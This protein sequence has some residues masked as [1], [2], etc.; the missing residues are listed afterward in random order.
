M[1]NFSGASRAFIIGINN[2]GETVCAASARISTQQGSAEEILQKSTANT[3]NASLIAKVLRSGHSSVIEHTFFNLAF[4]DVSVA[5]EQFMIEFRLASFT[6]KSRRYVDFS[7]VGYYT[8][9]FPTDEPWSAALKESYS[10]HMDYLFSEY[11]FLLS[12][13]IPKEDARFVLPYCYRSNFY[14]S[15]NARELTHVLY[16]MLY[17]RGKAFGEIRTIG[18]DLLKQARELC[19]G[20]FED[21]PKIQNKE[22]VLDLSD[23]IPENS[24]GQSAREKVEL[25]AAP[26]NAATVAAKAALISS[27]Q[28]P[29]ADADKILNNS[30]VKGEIIKRLTR[31]S[32]PRELEALN[33]TFRLNGI[34]LAGVTHVVRHRMQNICVPS[35]KNA[36]RDNYVLPETVAENNELLRRYEEIF[37]RN[38]ELC[39]NLAAQGV[40]EEMLVYYTLS[41]NTLDLLTTMNAREL[42]LFLRL[43]TCMRAQWE[44]RGY[45]MDMLKKLRASCPEIFRYYGA[46]CY[47]DSK[48]PEGKL[49]C[50]HCAEMQKFFSEM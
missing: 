34:S 4:S 13:G 33:Y 50:G 26:E 28:M 19:P 1:S 14:C 5:V 25:L 43:R 22:D 35:L 17:G 48:C 10:K 32:R 39:R 18:E 47:I 6:V 7:K 37:K 3:N 42:L 2:T 31:C 30:L 11:E 20:I 15:M 45:A 23:L 44:V 21:F 9:D 16:A 46:S 12:Q 41:G 24:A 36:D 29:S 27:T 38:A 40:P 49:T 8:P